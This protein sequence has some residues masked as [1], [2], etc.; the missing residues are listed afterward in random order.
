M[1]DAFKPLLGRLADGQTLTEPDAEADPLVEALK[2]IDVE[3]SIENVPPDARRENHSI[4]RLSDSRMMSLRMYVAL[5]QR[6]AAVSC[7]ST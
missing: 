4:I 2:V 5:V 6:S 7:G 1:S 3:G